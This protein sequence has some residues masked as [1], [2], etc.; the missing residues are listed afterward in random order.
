MSKAV[1]L[2]GSTGIS[3]D[4]HD[5]VLRRLGDDEAAVVLAVTAPDAAPLLIECCPDTEALLGHVWRAFRHWSDVLWATPHQACPVVTSLLGT[6]C[7]V[8]AA[9]SSPATKRQA[10]SAITLAYLEHLP[11]RYGAKQ[12]RAVDSKNQPAVVALWE[13]TV[14]GAKKL[15]AGAEEW[16]ETAK[17]FSSVAIKNAKGGGAGGASVGKDWAAQVRKSMASAVL[18]SS[19]D[20]ALLRTCMRILDRDAG[21]A[22]EH[23]EVHPR[24]TTLLLDVL[25]ACAADTGASGFLQR[26]V[27]FI[28]RLLPRLSKRAL[29]AVS[30]SAAESKLQGVLSLLSNTVT[31]LPVPAAASDESVSVDRM[32]AMLLELPERTFREVAVQRSLQHIIA[33]H[34]SLRPLPKLALVFSSSWEEEDRGA[35]HSAVARV[36]ALSVATGFIKAIEAMGAK[37]LAFKQAWHDVAYVLPCAIAALAHPN[38][39]VREAAVELMVAICSGANLP[40]GK[41]AKIEVSSGRSDVAAAAIQAT[42]LTKFCGVLVQHR[43]S[44]CMDA[45][46]LC[47][48][49]VSIFGEDKEASKPWKK[50][51]AACFEF[52]T[53]QGV[54]LGY[55]R[56]LRDTSWRLIG[57]LA[58]SV[59][60]TK[61]LLASH[62]DTWVP[63]RVLALHCLEQL[64]GDDASASAVVRCVMDAFVFSCSREGVR[65]EKERF[66]LM[67]DALG[68]PAEAAANLLAHCLEAISRGSWSDSLTKKQ[69]ADLFKTLAAL[70]PTV[71]PELRPTL[72]A[73]LK[74]VPLQ[75]ATASALLK[76]TSTRCKALASLPPVERAADENVSSLAHV[77]AI[78]ETLELKLTQEGD[79]AV[80]ASVGEGG[81]LLGDLFAL[82]TSLT[83]LAP[84]DSDYL[85][86]MTLA[87]VLDT[88]HKLN[89]KGGGAAATNASI[90][91]YAEAV[92]ARAQ[93][94]SSLQTRS[95]AM[96]TLA[97]MTELNPSVLLKSVVPM[98]NTMGQ[99]SADHDDYH[100]FQVVEQVLQQVLPPLKTHGLEGGVTA[101]SLLLDIGKAFSG[102]RFQ[103]KLGVLNV[104]LGCLSWET[105]PALVVV[106]M[107]QDAGVDHM[108]VDV[109]ASGV[110]PGSSSSEL[111]HAIAHR[112]SPAVQVGALVTLLKCVQQCSAACEVLAGADTGADADA[113]ANPFILELEAAAEDAEFMVLDMRHLITT[114]QGAVDLALRCADFVALHL[115][116]RT[117]HH[118]ILRLSPADDQALQRIYLLLCQQLL[119]ARR[120]VSDLEGVQT[121][122]LSAAL[123]RVLDNVQALL[124]VSSFIAV[125]Q[126]L[127][128]DDELRV[129][130][131]A[132]EVF[133]SRV[134]AMRDGAGITRDEEA[135]FVEMLPELLNALG[136]PNTAHATEQDQTQIVYHKQTALLTIDIL[137]RS[138]ASNHPDA[139]ATAL[140]T[141]VSLLESQ[142]AAKGDGRYD[143][144][145]EQQPLVPVCF[146][147]IATLCG[148]LGT[149]C[150]PHLPRFLPLMLGT[151]QSVNVGLAGELQAKAIDDGE[152][153]GTSAPLSGR[154]LLRRSVLSGMAVVA[155]H[156]PQFLH[157][158]LER[159]L[160][161]THE[162]ELLSSD[163]AAEQQMVARVLKHVAVGT[164]VRLTLPK[165]VAMFDLCVQSV[166][167]E[168]A[169]TRLFGVFQ[170]IIVACSPRDLVAHLEQMTAFF[171]SSL[172]L[173]RRQCDALAAEEIG[174]ME[175]RIIEA[176]LAM[177]MK[178]NESQLSEF[179]AKLCDWKAVQCRSGAA[180]AE[181][182][183]EA[184]GVLATKVSFFHVV[185]ELAGRLRSIFV[186]FFEHIFEDCRDELEGLFGA[187]DKAHKVDAS[188]P[189]P[190][191]RRRKSKEAT[192]A[193]GA[194]DALQKLPEM[195]Q[196]WQLELLRLVVSTLHKCFQ[197]DIRG[198]ATQSAV[199][200][201]FVSKARVELIRPSLVKQI[202]LSELD[203][204]YVHACVVP[205]IGQLAAAAG[206]DVLWK[207]L[208]NHILMNTRDP[209]AAV[210][211][212]SLKALKELFEV[213]GEEYLVLLP[214]CLPFLSELLEDNNP[215]VEAQ[216]RRTLK[217]AEDLSGED[218]DTF[219]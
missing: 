43:Q 135:L 57:A 99:E 174:R 197:Y 68:L 59:D 169:V 165:V 124:S 37:D 73:A 58:Q 191:K 39:R 159:M 167:T 28:G 20:D 38:Q 82:L 114:A 127:L 107:G 72:Q 211:L 74:A 120:D 78:L 52:L 214:E 70:I 190:K 162:G 150:F 86:G 13:S 115:E 49:L 69:N 173:R 5:V 24:V 200:S 219:L 213:I 121:R 203:A 215:D 208:N 64:H 95:A 15:A 105:L 81:T 34:Y 123:D 18:Q 164:P 131:K 110:E 84:E 8:A 157:P 196:R 33:S 188:G 35:C 65:L 118:Q 60:E 193:G 94:A 1:Q 30:D 63:C 145:D 90:G 96:H 116:T 128:Q 176:L 206:S 152:Q 9:S 16:G 204:D 182:G 104:L 10:G 180:S 21:L 61:S 75:P 155:Q 91:R 119:M 23:T 55:D 175:E 79:G 67:V 56:P 179:F 192:D 80:A 146:L 154:A 47:P 112:T 108:E 209:S 183:E 216:C 54:N 210:R 163:D 31:L 89:A 186:P 44:L 29:G 111:C 189:K 46:S 17:L 126:E 212:S 140:G 207:P 88:T 129:R 85:E 156:L 160:R 181:G 122:D 130:R 98:L 51:R 151:L 92:L 12:A 62:P 205:C 148:T 93:G 113:D 36:R 109:E 166:N 32:V 168:K 170:E 102:V 149:R 3:V 66:E 138:F 172:A 83:G 158:Y 101:G 134:Q 40:S 125:I 11:S 185:D 27:P 7:A 71:P 42:E 137:S 136:S 184:G 133:T 132:L 202:T 153:D 48:C 26:L 141:I 198:N 41:A 199:N 147:C 143:E 117:L 53:S 195:S 100:M 6:L 142:Q 217:F 177:V 25:E 77:G 139:F 97:A 218:L 50:M 178:M 14:A 144:E 45:A 87:M 103:R 161:M 187:T 76:S 171:L 19:T 106:A 22:G 2:H 201:K 194:A 4:L